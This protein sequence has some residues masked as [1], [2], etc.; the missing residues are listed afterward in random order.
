M[1]KKCFVLIGVFITVTVSAGFAEMEY[2]KSRLELDY[3]TSYKLQK[4][5]QIVNPDASKNLEPVYGL[6]GVAAKEVMNK[7]RE[8]FKNAEKSPVYELSIG[9]KK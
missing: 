4:Y 9:G 2:S 1:I 3:G 7:Y 8:G 6:D 5:N